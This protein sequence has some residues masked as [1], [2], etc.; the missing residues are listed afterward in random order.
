MENRAK[1]KVAEKLAQRAKN[2]V[3][4]MD[5]LEEMLAVTTDLTVP[6]AEVGGLLRGGIG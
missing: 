3:N 5:R 1:R 2:D 4:T 6:D